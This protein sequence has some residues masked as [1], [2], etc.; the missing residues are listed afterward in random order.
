MKLIKKN[1]N[2]RR[3]AEN[4]LEELVELKF[5]SHPDLMQKLQVCKGEIYEATRDPVFGCG[6]GLS[7]AHALTADK[8]KVRSNRMGEILKRVRD[9]CEPSGTH[10]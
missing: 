10:S 6:R 2:W 3:N 5:R 4:V 1:D 9:N 7:E 8:V